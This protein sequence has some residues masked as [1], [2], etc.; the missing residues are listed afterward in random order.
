MP[1]T[2][3]PKPARGFYAPCWELPVQRVTFNAPTVLIERFDNMYNSGRKRWAG[4]MLWLLD[5]TPCRQSEAFSNAGRYWYDLPP[6][7][8][9]L[10]K[11][12]FL[13]P[14]ALCT[15]HASTASTRSYLPTGGGSGANRRPTGRRRA[16]PTRPIT[17]SPR[18]SAPTPCAMTTTTPTTGPCSD[19]GET[20]ARGL[21]AAGLP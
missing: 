9:K 3:K 5:L 18:T 2:M 17:G 12:S 11:F 16:P 10:R 4:A 6:E 7:R 13:A 15:R 14:V 19:R 21:T 20:R 8:Q 1:S